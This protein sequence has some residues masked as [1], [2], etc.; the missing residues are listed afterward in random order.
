MEGRRFFELLRLRIASLPPF[1]Q[2]RSSVEQ[3]RLLPRDSPVRQRNAYR[4]R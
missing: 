3:A 2:T 1:F 4:I